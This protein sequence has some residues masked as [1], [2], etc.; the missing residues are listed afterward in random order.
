MLYGIFGVMDFGFELYATI[1]CIAPL[2]ILALDTKAM[3]K[4]MNR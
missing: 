3:L 1:L 2:T 4:E